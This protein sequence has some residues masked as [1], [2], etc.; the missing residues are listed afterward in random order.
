M[1]SPNFDALSVQHSRNIGDTV[2]SASSNGTAVSSAQRSTHINNACRLFVAKNVELE[3]YSPI[4][5]YVNLTTGTLSSNTYSLTSATPD[6]AWIISLSD[7]S[8]GRIATKLPQKY[9]KLVG[10][11]QNSYLTASTTNIYYMQEGSSL[12]VY[13]AGATDAIALRYVGVHTDLSAGGSTDILIESPYWWMVLE[14]A[15]YYAM[16]ERPNELNTARGKM[17]FDNAIA[18]ITG[19]AQS[20]AKGN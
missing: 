16:L 8:E 4:K 15:L 11:S 5:G 7:T 19:L 18:G 12:H 3:N 17:A 1:S 14:L 13:G 6:V 9:E 2:S 10:T 20:G